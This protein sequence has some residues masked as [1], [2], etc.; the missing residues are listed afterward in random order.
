M[1]ILSRLCLSFLIC[2]CSVTAYCQ[3]AQPLQGLINAVDSI[4]TRMPIEKLFLQTDKPY[5]TIGDTLHFKAY[6]LNADYL[7]PS[8]RSGLLYVE[9][10]DKD[11]KAV[12][13]QMVPLSSGLTWGDITFAEGD[14]PEGSYTLRAYTNWMLN[15]G[16]DYIFTKSI[17]LSPANTGSTLI[18]AR[19][20]LDKQT[21]QDKIFANLLFSGIDKQ[22]IR[23][24]DL[25]LKVKDGKK[26]LYR[27]K[28]T[29]DL[30]GIINV[31]F[32]LPGK[33]TIKNLAIEAQDTKASESTA[34]L[35]IPVSILR[36]ENT[37]LQFMPE[38]GPLVAGIP[39]RV[40]FK[41]LSENGKGI[42]VS[43]Q[44]LNSKLQQV[45]VFKSLHSGMG[46]FEMM[47]QAGEIYTAR[48]TSPP[49]INKI[50]PLPQLSLAGTNLRVDDKDPDS[51]EVS[52]SGTTA[53]AFYLLAQARGVVCYAGVVHL[54]EKTAIKRVIAKGLFPTGIT[55]F[56]LLNTARLPLNER[57]VYVD[58]HDNL[59]ITVTPDKKNYKTRDSVALAIQVTDKQGNPVQGSFS[60][61]VTDDTQVRPDSTG[62]NITNN[63]LLTS[64]LKGTVESPEYY[65]QDSTANVVT[66][67]DNLLLTQGWVGY[68][69][70]QVFDAKPQP[71]QHPA[72][73]EFT[74]KG[75]VT[76]IFN[77]PVAKSG[78]VL[79]STRPLIVKDTITNKNGE[80]VFKNL[81][82]T[83]TAVFKIQAR[84]K[85]GKS[86]NVGI[87]ID[88]V[89]PPVYA[90]PGRQQMPW[91]VN[92]DTT[93][94]A[95]T[96][97]KIAQQKAESAYRGEGHVLKEVVIKAQKIIKGSKNLNGPGEADEV[98][99]EKELEKAGKMSLGELLEKRVKGFQQSGIWSPCGICRSVFASYVIKDAL[100]HLVFDGVDANKLFDGSDL[101]PVNDPE[102]RQFLKGNYLDYYT[103]E[104]IKGIE[105]MYSQKYT[106]DYKRSGQLFSLNIAF[107]E[108]TTRGGKGPFMSAT[109]GTY[110]YKPLAY[111]LPKKFYRPR[112]TVK[113]STVALGSD[114]RSTIHWEPHIVTDST[115]RAV[116]SFYSAD[117]PGSYSIIIQGTD[118]F[119][120]IGASRRK[121]A[122]K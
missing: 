107:I 118:L 78:V 67:R 6:L 95:N 18:N 24:L 117:K 66:A 49:N 14:I 69:W 27:D 121:I 36:P 63:L 41:A 10:D 8:L 44:I 100:V 2:V 17:Y 93:L 112:Y 119:G 103:A 122:V 114:L 37:D 84:N 89:L 60:L 104:D 26:T 3:S 79:L 88:E 46:S 97:T 92:S 99:D 86:F 45:A 65:F 81:F 56:T 106:G 28:A 72:E 62:D 32:N 11:N 90:A 87:T 9:L 4:G 120:Q 73:L 59:R 51:L 105:V 68:N 109:P 94:L 98:I 12:K 75:K 61:A 19:F 5:Y 64:D 77:S 54:A 42:E 22:P 33:T 57:I 40:G 16:E 111:T 52:V 47:P 1:K 35:I 116:V 80:F 48:I 76:N 115:G 113:N 74:V 39:T 30:D 38:G 55:R 70:K 85:R 34:R 102:R 58:H 29:T 21:G 50:Y 101:G 7:T 20:K 13:R 82:I 31:N 108:I 43:G 71:I 91:Y 110:L 96:Y 23:L 53:G 15:F 83:D 25:Q